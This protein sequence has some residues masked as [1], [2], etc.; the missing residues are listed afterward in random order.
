MPK[1]PRS[2]RDIVE[3]VSAVLLPWLLCAAAYLFFAGL[4]FD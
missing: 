4:E 1:K 3:F 2:L